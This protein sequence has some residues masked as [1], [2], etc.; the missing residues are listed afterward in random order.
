MP[1]R[2]GQGN[3]WTFRWDDDYTDK[4]YQLYINGRL[5]AETPRPGTEKKITVAVTGLFQAEILAVDP[6]DAG[7]DYSD[8]LTG[9][10]AVGG[11]VKLTWNRDPRVLEEISTAQIYSDHGTGTIDGDNPINPEPVRNFPPGTRTW[12]HFAGPLGQTRH[13]WGGPGVP[14]GKRYHGLG[15]F[16]VGMDKVIFISEQMPPGTYQFRVCQ[17][18][19]AGNA[20]A[21]TETTVTVDCPP[22]PPVRL[23][24]DDYAAGVLTLSVT[25]G[26][27][28][29]PYA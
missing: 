20:D 22:T 3:Q 29:N 7:T 16:Q 14:W 5:T 1:Q 19:A 2:A 23:L 8:Y 13:G 26:T 21:G 15:P 24:A 6:E 11:R 4:I 10:D 25:A 9:G 12:G 18:D 28:L 17:V 27:E